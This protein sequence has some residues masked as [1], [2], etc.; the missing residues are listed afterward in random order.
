MEARGSSGALGISAHTQNTHTFG[1]KAGIWQEAG[2]SFRVVVVGCLVGQVYPQGRMSVHLDKLK[3]GD[4]M[5]FKGPKGRFQYTPNMK[6]KI[7]APPARIHD[8]RH[9][10][11]SCAKQLPNLFAVVLTPPELVD[12]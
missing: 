11:K 7:G 1:R 9:L 3:I 8:A 2:S 10:C 12:F 4:T 6:G 5:L